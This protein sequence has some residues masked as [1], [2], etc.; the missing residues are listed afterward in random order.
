MAG[1]TR[2]KLKEHLEGI[3]RN[4]DWV[5]DHVSKSLTLIDDKK[6]DLSEALL[7]LGQAVEEL[8]KL[9]KEIYLKI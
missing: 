7:S 9:T 6:P 8:D 4:F 3:H 1:N 2:G 5:L